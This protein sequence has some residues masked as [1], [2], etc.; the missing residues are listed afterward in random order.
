MASL[1]ERN[2]IYY[3][4]FARRVDGKLKQK[5]YSLGTRNEKK[6]EALKTEYGERYRLGEIDP[7]GSWTPKNEAEKKRKEK[8]SR[9]LTKAIERFLEERSH[10]RPVTRKGYRNVLEYFSEHVGRSMPVRLITTDDIRD[11]CFKDRYSAATQATYL[12]NCKIFFRWLEEIGYV[13]KDVTKNIRYPNQHRSVSDRS[14]SEEQFLKILRVF[15]SAQRDKIKAGQK[16]GLHIWFKPAMALGFYAGLRRKEIAQLRWDKVDLKRRFLHI[17][18]TKSGEDRVVPIQKK[19]LPYLQAWHR[20]CGYPQEGLV[21]FKSNKPG[22]HAGRKI[23]LRLDHLTKTFKRYAK[24]AKM[25]DS[26]CLHGLR[27]SFATNMMRE[28]MDVNEVASMTGHADLSSM[29]P[30]DHLNE[31]DLKRK[32]ERLGI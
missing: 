19:L 15:K 27:H 30:Y 16:R 3:I 2:G 25:P 26:V 17:T 22:Q 32:M 5:V 12:R 13:E 29:R 1:R 24:A 18:E 28:G 8:R 7:F 21:F 11:F 4:V 10:V 20:L 14:I 31:R 6:A 9:T 23:L